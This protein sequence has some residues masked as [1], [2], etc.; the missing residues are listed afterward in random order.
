MNFIMHLS[1]TTVFSAI[2]LYFVMAVPANSQSN[3]TSD[4]VQSIKRPRFQISLNGI[5][6]IM[7]TNLRF[8]SSTGILGVKI[9]FEDNLGMDKYRV[10][11][12]FNARFNIKNRHNIF[13][14]YYG[15]PRDAYYVTKQDI[16]YGDRFIPQGTEVFS[17][18]NT[19]VYS[20]GY[21]YDVVSDSRSRLGLFVNFY[22]LTVAT[23]VSSSTE[24]LNESF[25]V[26]A[27]LPNFGAQAY[28]K[29]NDWFG[30]SGLISLFF[31]S[32]DEFSGSIHTLSGQMDF[33]LTRWLE[34]GLG[35]YLFDLNLEVSKTQFTG[36]FD[37]LYKGPYL[38]LGFRF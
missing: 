1:R 10:M 7:E 26:T 5:Y 4:L 30:V 19:N 21:M 16:E 34:A 27:P 9:N 37:Y 28:Y 36:L 17:Y 31:L 11:P 6:A 14:L 13:A 22:V 8:E 29:I 3:D 2:I 35:Y 24:P 12:M 32:I 33:Y 38:S 20:L 23:G 15:L 25:R 18:F